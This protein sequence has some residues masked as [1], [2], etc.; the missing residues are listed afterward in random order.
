MENTCRSHTGMN[1]NPV[2][3]VTLLA[4]TRGTST[5]EERIARI[6]VQLDANTWWAELLDE[7]HKGEDGQTG[8]ETIPGHNPPSP[9]VT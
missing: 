1:P 4:L 8:P 5:D 3:L 2:H 6:R 7:R 9:P